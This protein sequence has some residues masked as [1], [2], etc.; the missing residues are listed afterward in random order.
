MG[1]RHAQALLGE[2]G[3]VACVRGD[4]FSTGKQGILWSRPGFS[5]S[6]SSPLSFFIYFVVHSGLTKGFS[7]G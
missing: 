7:L 1:G 6:I 4:D 5:H 3:L 2:D